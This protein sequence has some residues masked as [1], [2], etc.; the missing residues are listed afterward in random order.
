MTNNSVLPFLLCGPILRR[1]EAGL[2]SVFVA[3]TQ[4]PSLEL[5]VKCNDKL[6]A[7]VS[8]AHSFQLGMELWGSL[9]VFKPTNALSASEVYEYNLTQNAG[10]LLTDLGLGYGHRKLPSFALAPADP[11]KIRI[12]HGSCRK[13][14]AG[15]MEDRLGYVDD[16]I[17][18]SHNDA[19]GRPHALFMTGDQIYA[20]GVATPFLK[21]IRKLIRRLGLPEETQDEKSA[22]L[23][24]VDGASFDVCD[25]EPGKRKRL[26]QKIGSRQS[27]KPDNHAMF[28]GEYVGLYLLAWSETAWALCDALS[29]E[30]TEEDHWHERKS[31]KRLA[32]TRAAL[33]KVRRALA[34]V[35]TFM[36]F[37]DH[38]VTDSWLQNPSWTKTFQRTEIGRRVLMNGL[39]GYLFFQAL[40]N[41][42]DYLFGCEDPKNW[43]TS[44]P[45]I[46]LS[47]I[48]Q[49][50]SNWINPG[51]S[52]EQPAKT[53][54]ETISEALVQYPSLEGT[55][56]SIRWSYVVRIG[57][58]DVLVLDT[59]TQRKI[60]GENYD[61][62]ELD[63][64]PQL[65]STAHITKQVS[66]VQSLRIN[67]SLPRPL[68][69]VSAAPVL[70]YHRLI[71]LQQ[72]VDS[73]FWLQLKFDVESWALNTAAFT[74]LLKKL[75]ACHDPTT[76][77]LVFLSGDVHYN[78][79]FNLTLRKAPKANEPFNNF[80]QGTVLCA[81]VVCSAL[82]NDSPGALTVLV[83]PRE[84]K[85]HTDLDNNL[86]LNTIFSTQNE[87][88]IDKADREERRLHRALT[89]SR[90]CFPFASLGEIRLTES[91]V[92]HHLYIG[93]INNSLAKSM[94]SIPVEGWSPSLSQPNDGGA[95]T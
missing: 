13:P 58:V 20:D 81:Q 83:T 51:A 78:A 42:P 63:R 43:D 72:G 2:V 82:H 30:S 70:N 19:E 93:R 56:G 80:E 53:F 54:Y 26:A 29:D 75:V 3:T 71:T 48:R 88:K 73:N 44:L 74:A 33:P 46:N 32:E 14:D 39:L 64:A 52:Q 16:L 36:I 6:I 17:N 57:G 34:N 92:E 18:D 84:E 87:T 60:D 15:P 61:E 24:D 21:A 69:V 89:N 4:A 8:N 76:A 25:L 68:L 35:P 38:E 79:S 55:V 47:L 62:V 49:A 12:L 91:S 94:T 31:M 41:D 9:V 45:G 65:I 37:D 11:L 22:L 85:E 10:D 23:A 1:V 66:L 27:Y 77:P 28:F 90:A 50:L 59:R 95:L 40:G 5:T 67:D 7:G 86:Q